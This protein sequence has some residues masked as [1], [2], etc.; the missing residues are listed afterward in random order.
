MAG[1]STKNLDKISLDL[2]PAILGD[3]FK[4]GDGL[5]EMGIEKGFNWKEEVT[6]HPQKFA[7]ARSHAQIS[8]S[9]G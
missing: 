1:N 7:Q 8:S 6:P 3:E 9:P 2:A 4:V 5:E